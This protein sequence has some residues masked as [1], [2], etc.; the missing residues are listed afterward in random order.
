MSK[1]IFT[2]YT[3][4]IFPFKCHSEIH[5]FPPFRIQIHD[6]VPAMGPSLLPGGRETK[7]DS[8]RYNEVKY[9]YLNG[10]VLVIWGKLAG[11]VYAI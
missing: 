2:K 3:L 10:Y 1:L 4:E 11:E 8:E 9:K 7:Q 5:L 6:W